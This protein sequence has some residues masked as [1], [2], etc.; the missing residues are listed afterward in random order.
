MSVTLISTPTGLLVALQKL[1]PSRTKEVVKHEPAPLHRAVCDE[2]L[3]SLSARQEYHANSTLIAKFISRLRHIRLMN[4]PG[5]QDRL[6]MGYG[7][8]V[9]CMPTSVTCPTTRT[10]AS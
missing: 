2:L 1:L 9:C 10:S 4:A 7:I 3:R 8:V 5:M 6:P